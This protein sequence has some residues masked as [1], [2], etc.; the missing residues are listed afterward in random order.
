V[1]RTLGHL[2]RRTRLAPWVTRFRTCFEIPLEQL[3]QSPD[4]F[5]IYRRFV[6]ESEFKRFPGGWVYRGEKYPDYLFMGGA[7]FAIFRTA[8]NYLRG[9]GVDIGAGYWEF[10][11]S[12]PVDPWRGEG[13]HTRIEDIPAASLD[14]IFS[15]HTL[16]HIE[17]W[18][19]TLVQW[20]ALLKRGGRLFL[21][22][23]HPECLI[24][25]RGAPG[26]DEWHK[27][28]P[29]PKI[30]AEAVAALKLAIVAKDDGP[31]GMMSFFI[32]AEKL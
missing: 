2:L 29:E 8:K 13:L 6:A 20:A 1:R 21:Y 11:G 4:Y 24:W 10:P 15:S 22:L 7:S 9:H 12:M 25:H 31:D 26:I 18:R 32:C 14:Y 28:I 27:W 5:R 23:P 3:P 19:G 17:D 16:E 30:V